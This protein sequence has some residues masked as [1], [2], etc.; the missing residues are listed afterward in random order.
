MMSTGRLSV[1]V[2]R[3]ACRSG[4]LAVVA[5]KLGSAATAASISLSLMAMVA[6]AAHGQARQGVIMAAAIVHKPAGEHLHAP[7]VMLNAGLAQSILERSDA[8]VD[9]DWFKR[10]YPCH[11]A[12]IQNRWQRGWVWAA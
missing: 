2:A 12:C 3:S 10:G 7:D 9:G 11:L 6:H 4:G 8:G 1:P 5:L